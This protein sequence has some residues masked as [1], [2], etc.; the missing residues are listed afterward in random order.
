MFF[1]QRK[2]LSGTNFY[3]RMFYPNF[4]IF[5]QILRA[6]RFSGILKRHFDPPSRTNRCV[7]SSNE[8]CIFYVWM[9][10]A[11]LLSSY[12]DMSVFKNRTISCVHVASTPFNQ[13]VLKNPR[14]FTLPDKHN[15]TAMKKCTSR[16][17]KN[18]Q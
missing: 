11:H 5:I 18:G 6:C 10:S 9:F 7:C 15:V 14:V 17:T 8:F 2:H 12:S 4:I 13:N 1:C 16:V 3:R